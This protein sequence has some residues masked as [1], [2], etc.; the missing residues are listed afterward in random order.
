[1]C[2][3]FFLKNH[4][5]LLYRCW[6]GWREPILNLNITPPYCMYS[7]S[8][9]TPPN[10]PGVGCF[11]YRSTL[12]FPGVGCFEYHS[13]LFCLG[14]G[15]FKYHS[16]LLSRCWMFQISLHPTVQVLDV[17]NITPPYC[18]GAGCEWREPPVPGPAHH[19]HPHHRV[20][21]D[22]PGHR[23]DQVTS[24]WCSSTPDCH[25][26]WPRGLCSE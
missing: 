12:F 3:N 15:C 16:T 23:D 10:C 21:P 26:T 22:Q 4:S 9:I 20:P 8:N 25:V 11:K 18:P 6:C 24:W 19:L 5:N 17:S 2:P 14:L 7:C 1:M 13:T